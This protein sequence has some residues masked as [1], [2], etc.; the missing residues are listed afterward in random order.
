ML[1]FSGFCAGTTRRAL[2]CLR[3]LLK[4]AE[5]IAQPNNSSRPKQ[6]GRLLDY[7]RIQGLLSSGSGETASV[8]EA[9]LTA[10]LLK[11]KQEHQRGSHLTIGRSI[12]HWE[13]KEI[14]WRNGGNPLRAK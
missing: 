13:N 14:R 6:T 8:S 10:P 7:L 12:G 11:D 1:G 2:Q 4:E 9:D 3:D 5:G